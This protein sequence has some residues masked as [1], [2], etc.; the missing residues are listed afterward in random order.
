MALNA[1]SDAAT[2]LAVAPASNSA[3]AYQIT[4][5][6]WYNKAEV[7]IIVLLCQR[8][9]MIDL[10]GV[11]HMLDAAPKFAKEDPVREPVRSL[12]LQRDVW[13]RALYLS[14]A[15]PGANFRTVIQ[16]HPRVRRV[17]RVKDGARELRT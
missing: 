1:S 4:R 6:R 8:L 13:Q 17:F 2:S 12:K 16:R 5:P 14:K 9:R 11:E 15:A 3:S 10:K 7:A